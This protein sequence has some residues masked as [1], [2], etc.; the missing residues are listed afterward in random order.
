MEFE[1]HEDS[2]QTHLGESAYH[3]S[4]RESNVRLDRG[5]EDRLCEAR[6]DE[7]MRSK[8]GET[9]KRE[10]NYLMATALTSLNVVWPSK[11]FCTPSCIRV[12]MPSSMAA[13][14]ISSVLAFV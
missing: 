2:V 7:G 4:R 5:Y 3:G 1:A 6:N 9:Y 12:V 10:S 11:A 13:C 14:S 8:Y